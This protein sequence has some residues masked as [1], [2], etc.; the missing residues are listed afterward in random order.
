MAKLIQPFDATQWDPTQSAG[1]LPLGKHPVVI[2]SSEVKAT[3]AGDGGFLLLTLKIID[4]PN[5]GQT[6]SYRLNLYN[7]NP[8]A[9]AIANS[10][11]SAICYVTNV[12]RVTDDT[13][14]LHN[15]PFVIDVGNQELTAEQKTSQLAG[16]VV[17]PYTEVKK[18]YYM[19]GTEPK[20]QSPGGQQ[21]QQQPAQN[22]Q[23]QQP[24][25][26]QQQPTQGGQAGGWGGGQQSQTPPP[27]QQ[28]QPQ[29]AAWGQPPAQQ[30][31]AGQGQPGPAGNAGWQPQGGGAPNQQPAQQG[32]GGGVP[33]GKQ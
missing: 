30:G 21:T 17:T 26:G 27:E 25:Q 28:Q 10:Q 1:S 3:K 31:N 29:G 12:F 6:G 9:V 19:N 24:A 22:F 32:G 2:E 4:G 33:W 20:G 13:G 8:K 14:V 11:F 16:Q 5:A 18:V 7:A 15:I 23:Q